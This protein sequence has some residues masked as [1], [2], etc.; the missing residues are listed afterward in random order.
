MDR[1]VDYIVWTIVIPLVALVGV[2]VYVGTITPASPADTP[3][4][5][6][7]SFKL[8]HCADY[9]VTHNGQ[10]RFTRCPGSRKM[11]PVTTLFGK[12]VTWGI[13]GLTASAE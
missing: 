12:H 3:Y 9:T 1:V 6:I 11:A 8:D 4:Q 5:L 13:F 7:Q 10:K 2:V